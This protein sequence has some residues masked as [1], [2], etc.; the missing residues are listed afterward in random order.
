MLLLATLCW[1]LSFPWGKEWLAAAQPFPGGGRAGGLLAALTLMGVRAALAA[2]LL[3]AW[4]PALL[5]RA[6][7]RERAVAAL[8]G[9]FYLGGSVLQSWGQVTTN[10]SLSAF[11]VSLFS[12]WA[13]L[14]AWACGGLLPR[15]LTLLGLAAALAGAAVLA[16]VRLDH[17]PVPGEGE[18][19]ALL[20]SVVIAGQIV[21]LD[22]LAR[23]L[24][25]SRLTVTF[26]GVTAVLAFA[27]GAAVAARGPGLD[28]WAR[29]A[30]GTLTRAEAVRPL[31]LLVL[32]PTVLSL[33]WMNTYQPHVSAA[34]ASLIYLLEPAF[35]AAFSVL[36]GHEGVTPALLAGGALILAGNLLAELPRWLPTPWRVRYDLVQG[37]DSPRADGGRGEAP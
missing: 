12:G 10:P 18:W 33:H 6:T 35:A 20:A 15:P 30:A 13:P 23:G 37:G 5:T 19:L 28:A 32:F 17:V 27:G 24:D 22:R 26:F 11:Y 8:L 36:L 29:W 9:V 1:A 31:L 21:A 16:G 3:A 25:P 4:R 14:L 7:A 2:L 34:R